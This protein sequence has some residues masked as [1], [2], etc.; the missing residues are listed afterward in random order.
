MSKIT[1]GVIK[2]NINF[3][4]NCWKESS[5]TFCSLSPTQ[6]DF[7]SWFHS[8]QKDSMSWWKSARGCGKYKCCTSSNVTDCL[9]FYRNA[10]SRRTLF[11][12]PVCNSRWV[13]LSLVHPRQEHRLMFSRKFAWRQWKGAHR[14][15]V[16]TSSDNADFFFF[17]LF[18][19]T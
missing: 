2:K 1:A 4:D 14:A 6:M 5:S 16:I 8:V 11:P 9:L 3:T 12:F 10:G 13:E 19:L 7:I 15:D 18:F 17:V